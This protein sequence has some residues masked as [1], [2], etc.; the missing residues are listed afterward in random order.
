[1]QSEFTADHTKDLSPRE[2]VQS[3]ATHLRQQHTTLLFR[4]ASSFI[5]TY[6]FRQASASDKLP[7]KADDDAFGVEGLLSALEAEAK[8]AAKEALTVA[9]VGIANVSLMVNSF[10]YFILSQT[11]DWK[12]LAPQL[13]STKIR[14]SDIQTLIDRV[15]AIH[16]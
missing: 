3:W 16:D 10:L 2:A 8:R 12:V 14:F 4:S 11:L 1:M 5:P 13:P 9:I 6:E 7:A 15:W